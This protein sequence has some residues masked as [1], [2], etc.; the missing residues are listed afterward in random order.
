MHDP[1]P[2]VKSI[3]GKALQMAVSGERAAYLDATCEGYPEIR[4][5]VEA[6]LRALEGAGN[7]LEAP[8]RPGGDA[9]RSRP[10]GDPE[11]TGTLPPKKEHPGTVVA[12][13]Y[14]LL[15]QIGEG[16]MGAVWMAD[17]TEPVKRR[18]AVKLI[19]AE[20]GQSKTILARFEA[21]RQA[22]ALMNHPNI[23]KLLDAGTT[24]DGAPFFV[25]ELVRG[26]PLTDYC[27][28]HKLSVPERLDLFRR[29]CSA[30]HHAHQKGVIHRDLKPTNI[31]VESH[32]GHP[33]PKVIDF[34]LAKATT[35]IQLT[36]QTLFTAFG[37]VMGT[38][39]YMAPE[40]AAFNALDIDSRADIYA[41]GVI[42]YELLA[43]S[44][45][46]R[47][48]TLKTAA[49][50]E[51]LRV[52]RE[53]EPPPPSSRIGTSAGLPGIAANRQ[54]EPVKLGRFVKGDLDWIVMKAL[55]KERDRRYESATAF[56]ADVERF[57]AH[58]PVTAGPPS[59]WY[60]LRKFVRRNQGQVVA[61]SLVLVTLVAG[62]VG[63]GVGLFQANRARR[64]EI[65]QRNL[66]EVRRVSALKERDEKARALENAETARRDEAKA[67]N[68]LQAS[69]AVQ[70]QTAYDVTVSLVQKALQEND[71]ARAVA[72]LASCPEELRNW[73]WHFLNRQF[74]RGVVTLRPGYSRATA[75]TP[76][77]FTADGKWLVSNVG[78]TVR[79]RDGVTGEHRREW[80]FAAFGHTTQLRPDGR[81]VAVWNPAVIGG[82]KLNHVAG[83]SAADPNRD[84]TLVSI[85]T[86]KPV[87]RLID[88]PEKARAVLF[89]RDGSRV[90]TCGTKNE[91]RVWDSAGK[92]LHT[93]TTDGATQAVPVA[94]TPDGKSLVTNGVSGTFGNPMYVNGTFGSGKGEFRVWDVSTGTTRATGPLAPYEDLK[95]SSSSTGPLVPILP[96]GTQPFAV[97]SPDGRYAMGLASDVF[98]YVVDLKTGEEVLRLPG[99]RGIGFLANGSVLALNPDGVCATFELPGGKIA[100]SYPLPKV[101]TNRVGSLIGRTAELSANGRWLTLY[102][103]DEGIIEVRD[104]A[105]GREVATVPAGR[106]YF[107]TR[108]SHSAI[109]ADA[110]RLLSSAPNGEVKMWDLSNRTAGRTVNL[111]A[112]TLNT[113][114]PLAASRDGRRAVVLLDTPNADKPGVRRNLLELVDLHAGT[115][116]TLA[117][118]LG[119]TFN[120]RYAQ[121]VFSPDGR[122]VVALE[123]VRYQDKNKTQRDRLGFTPLVWDVETGVLQL[124]GKPVLTSINSPFDDI[125]IPQLTFSADGV[126]LVAHLHAPDDK[127]GGKVW[128]I[129]DVVPEGKPDRVRL[130][131]PAGDAS[132]ARVSADGRFVAVLGRSFNVPA[133]A[134]WDCAAVRQLWSVPV[135]SGRVERFV[136]FFSGDGNRLL[137][138]DA[139]MMNNAGR[140][141]DVPPRVSVRDSASGR[142]FS[143]FRLPTTAQIQG[144]SIS[145]DGRRVVWMSTGA[146]SR[147]A[148]YNADTGRELVSNFDAQPGA[149]H[150]SGVFRGLL[151]AD[152]NLLTGQKRP[153]PLLPKLNAVLQVWDGRPTTQPAKPSP[154]IDDWLAEA[155]RLTE[156]PDAAKRDPARALELTARALAFYPTDPGCEAAHGLALLR[157]KRHSE[158]VNV[159]TACVIREEAVEGRTT[160]AKL[161]D[162]TSTKVAASAGRK[163]AEYFLLALAT[164]GTGETERAKVWFAWGESRLLSPYTEG[165]RQ[166]AALRGDTT[167]EVERARAEPFRQEA[168]RALGRTA[169]PLAQL[170]LYELKFDP[171]HPGNRLMAWAETMSAENAAAAVWATEFTLSHSEQTAWLMYN[172]AC[173]YSLA[174]GKVA[175]RK[176]DYAVRAMEL[177]QKAVDGGFQKADVMKTDTDLDPLRGRGDFQKLL[178]DVIANTP[179]IERGPM[180]RIVK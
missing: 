65:D 139:P 121:V 114:L 125:G 13:R 100:K 145:P 98:K 104:A 36:E 20:R 45:P 82:A 30:V 152:G 62:I 12:G 133:L 76:E 96:G 48:D 58:E 70:R 43:G 80:D 179:V 83:K 5:D 84:V 38:P 63:T 22:I 149:G 92:L 50:D 119:Y 148:L 176:D 51:M 61:A 64:G 90:A 132:A 56:A 130:S 11:R 128:R 122:K 171:A 140:P 16:G 153:T 160:T 169:K 29:I 4:A 180:P 53:Q 97:V 66:A 87:A 138:T 14:K 170:E 147:S 95:A 79:V 42:L 19:R 164:A 32:D 40:Q 28:A 126:P 157:A 116:R 34:G 101:R 110:T 159:L 141:S 46:I 27:D 72:L 18:V 68:R 165:M 26:V 88:L 167:A 3:F 73:E 57:L 59:Q 47:R 41:L 108:G 94:F 74:D 106:Y 146:Q 21:E 24:D 99:F 123:G 69:V 172:A 162:G 144:L 173:V 103:Q 85:E 177:L 77:Q 117:E 135:E 6:L 178:A 86:G 33:V 49:L 78:T 10:G 35:G 124:R 91:V 129:V 150:S 163:A 158:A 89:S 2:D 105:T 55:A 134:V 112:R 7:F 17:Q 115:S 156:D 174:S 37:N 93:L 127:A 52:I 75:G 44:T 109:D 8:E 81:L 39:L 154:T 113:P 54:S 31:L 166:A 118:P 175:A 120:D 1:K 151:T 15:Q 107:G 142:E 60:R 102:Y 111:T 131:I 9:T 136:G 67:K 143:E 25:M 161:D 155:Y 137:M 23:A 71:S 168:A